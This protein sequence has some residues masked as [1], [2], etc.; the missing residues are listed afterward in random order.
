MCGQILFAWN[1]ATI[2][3]LRNVAIL[4]LQKGVAV[5]VESPCRSHRFTRISDKWE[6]PFPLSI[7]GSTLMGPS[8]VLFLHKIQISQGIRRAQQGGYITM[9]I[10]NPSSIVYFKGSTTFG[11]NPEG[12]PCSLYE[13]PQRNTPA[14][15]AF[16]SPGTKNGYNAN[17]IRIRSLYSSSGGIG[18]ENRNW[19]Q[20]SFLNLSYRNDRLV[21]F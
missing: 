9:S 1:P 7:L 18:G 13:L 21:Q 14:Q 6:R 10:R 19:K 5:F 12:P 3:H 11:P 2:A 16:M 4:C 15:R 20:H 17:Y 8:V